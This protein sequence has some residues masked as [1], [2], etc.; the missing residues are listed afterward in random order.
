[1]L[2]FVFGQSANTA[3]DDGAAAERVFPGGV[4]TAVVERLMGGDHRELGK[5]VHAPARFAIEDLLR[6][7]VLD[8]AADLDLE[9]RGVDLLD[10]ADTATARNQAI[11]VRLQIHGN[12]GNDTHAGDDD[13]SHHCGNDS[14]EAVPDRDEWVDQK[15]AGLLRL[16]VGLKTC[17]Q[18]A[19]GGA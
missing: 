17:F 9:F 11:P 7:P 8:L 6:R 10:V 5:A 16:S 15:P 12:W 4:E 13:P 1:M 3:A 18:L 2:L 14:F 19:G